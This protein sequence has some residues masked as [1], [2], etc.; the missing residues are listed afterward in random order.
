MFKYL[1]ISVIIVPTLIGIVAVIARESNRQVGTA[2]FGW[3]AYALLWVGLLHFL[4]S[5]WAW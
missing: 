4:R 2:W 1:L 3:L 5:R